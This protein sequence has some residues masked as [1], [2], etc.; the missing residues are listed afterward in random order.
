MDLTFDDQKMQ[1]YP[2][3]NVIYDLLIFVVEKISHSLTGVIHKLLF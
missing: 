3:V 1:F 2:S